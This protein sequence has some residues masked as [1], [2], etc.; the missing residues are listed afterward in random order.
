MNEINLSH[1]GIMRILVNLKPKVKHGYG[2]QNIKS[3]IIFL[4]LH[5]K[6]KYEGIPKNFLLQ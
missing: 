5:L 1:L 2:M 6:R 3:K 4:S